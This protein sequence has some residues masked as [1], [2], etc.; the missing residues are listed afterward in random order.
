MPVDN[1]LLKLIGKT[2][3]EINEFFEKWLVH[4][5]AERLNVVRSLR[6]HGILSAKYKTSEVVEGFKCPFHNF[7]IVKPCN[8]TSCAFYLPLKYSDP[9]HVESVSACK[10]CLVNGINMAKNNR[11]SAQ[12]AGTLLGLP[13]SEI[14]NLN[15]T[16]ITKIKKAKIKEYIEK[17]QIPRYSYIYGHCIHC[18][19]YIQDEIDMN[20][21]PELIIEPGKYGWC[22]SSC[23]DKKPKWQFLIE[24]EFGCS[25]Y[26]ALS[27][28]LF[29][30]KNFEAL[31]SL[32][33]VNKEVLLKNKSNVL[34]A[35]DEVKRYFIESN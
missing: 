24:N 22:S 32:F 10:N 15:S 35:L 13:I 6:S 33:G 28:G 2:P 3:K 23:R 25:H 9:S 4:S 20:L 7:A 11:M 14:N 26:H 29:I 1:T 12:E 30:F 31:N 19:I 34:E 8:L 17:Y 27:I 21:W 5:E 18:E 16:A